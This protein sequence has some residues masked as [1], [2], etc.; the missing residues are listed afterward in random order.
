MVECSVDSKAEPSAD[1]TDEVMA[2]STDEKRAGQM[3]VPRAWKWVDEKVC[4]KA[5][6]K[7]EWKVFQWADHLVGM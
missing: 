7:A 3:V 1:L 2:E 4:L 6:S 5:A